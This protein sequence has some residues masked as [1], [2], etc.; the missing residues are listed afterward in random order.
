[1]PGLHEST[2]P[3]APGTRRS[4]HWFTFNHHGRDF[5]IWVNEPADAIQ[6][7]IVR[8]RDFYEV[9]LLQFLQSM[10]PPSS[11]IV[12]V[13]ANIG[14]HTIYFSAICG[15]SKVIPIEP[16]PDV[17]AELKANVT[18]NDCISV[19]LSWLGFAVG[20]ESGTGSLSLS[21][22][23]E[24]ILNRGGMTVDLE[25]DGSD[26]VV[27]IRRLD[28]IDLPHVDLLKIDVEGAA[29]AVLAGAKALIMRCRP[30]LL[31]EIENDVAPAFFDWASEAG[32]RITAVFTHH[33]G[34]ANYIMLPIVEP[35]TRPVKS[36]TATT[37]DAAAW[38]AAQAEKAR[39]D[40][41]EATLAISIS[42]MR[43]AESR[44]ERAER[45]L[46]YAQAELQSEN[47]ALLARIAAERIE[48]E[49]LLANK[50][51][52]VEAMRA[53]F[54]SQAEAQRNR[55]LRERA[56]LDIR[57]RAF[58]AKRNSV[59]AKTDQAMALVRNTQSQLAGLEHDLEYQRQVSSLGFFAANALAEG[60]RKPIRAAKRIIFVAALE[61]LK[62]IGV[63]FR[64]KGKIVR[65]M[66][67]R[68]PERYLREF[69]ALGFQPVGSDPLNAQ[70]ASRA[71]RK[72]LVD[73]PSA[74]MSATV[75]PLSTPLETR[76]LFIDSRHPDITRDS[77]S[78]DTVNYLTW[79]RSL[80]QHID[81]V[82][83]DQYQKNERLERPVQQLGVEVVNA[84]IAPDFTAFLRQNAGVYDFAFLSR[85]HCGGRYLEE[86]RRCNPQAII[87][88]N[89]VDL[90]H[91]RED[92]EA[93]L[94][95]DQ[96]GVF[97]AALTRDRERH[98]VR[99][100]DLTIVV[101][102]S[103]R[104]ILESEVPGARVSVMPLY[105]P[106]PSRI[107]GF[108][109]RFGIGFV[110]GFDHAPNV[111]AVL[112]FLDKVWPS[113][114]QAEPTLTFSIA[115]PSLPAEISSNLPIGVHY[116]GQVPDLE[117]WL[118][119]LRLTVAPLRYGAGAKGKVASS[120]VNGVPVVG[121][122]VAFEGMAV[123]DACRI[124]TDDPVDMAEAVRRLHS[125]SELWTK[126]SACCRAFA[127]A[128]LSLDAGSRRFISL[129]K[130]V[131]TSTIPVVT[132][133]G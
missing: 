19:D 87:I 37:V 56:E 90:H 86:V 121:T 1:M 91:V 62:R 43:S 82:A 63:K 7:M 15:A 48:A 30:I 42:A 75:P 79:L 128:D 109:E 70:V 33:L 64:K 23:D 47:D 31:V 125:D 24:A 110:G 55:I 27:E 57:N 92:R 93:K 46:A 74:D 106:L 39:A 38:S 113:L 44:A 9:D 78:L 127:E 131:A 108:S 83:L 111:D 73:V 67:A 10:L 103:E 76:T 21:P 118:A 115:G 61:N 59:K 26:Q 53:E 112:F 72:E 104:K 123:P 96:A 88:F 105:R 80:G 85:V 32:Y 20:A 11:T 18:A 65:W 77:G 124:A 4:G 84:E 68:H 28:D 133:I 16:N 120:L 71:G 29:A 114:R 45:E 98:I 40:R 22:S 66:N 54:D 2:S 34:I 50:E 117:L 126:T 6:E 12:D 116:A 129:I 5:T 69:N 14:N 81:F 102:D 58:E 99:Q 51:K 130:D 89:T 100:A 97:A 13:G 122:S 25:S 107:P 52:Q 17:V 36:T 101:S 8:S 41:S 35:N 132:P 3:P 95:G 94:K 60:S 49:A 119:S